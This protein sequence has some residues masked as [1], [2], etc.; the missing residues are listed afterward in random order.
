MKGKMPW[1]KPDKEDIAIFLDM[2]RV[3]IELT[4]VVID[5]LS[6]IIPISFKQLHDTSDIFNYSLA[7]YQYIICIQTMNGTS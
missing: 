2:N 7:E 4:I 3:T 6:R 1:L 5:N